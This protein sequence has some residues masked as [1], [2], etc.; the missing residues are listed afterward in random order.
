MLL[1]VWLS[2]TLPEFFRRQCEAARGHLLFSNPN[3]PPMLCVFSPTDE[4]HTLLTSLGAAAN[5]PTVLMQVIGTMLSF[6]V[7]IAIFLISG[8]AF[9]SVTADSLFHYHTDVAYQEFGSFI[10]FMGL[11]LSVCLVISFIAALAVPK[12]LRSHALG[13]GREP[14]F[15]NII[16]N[17]SVKIYPPK[18]ERCSLLQV[19]KT[20]SENMRMHSFLLTDGGTIDKIGGWILHNKR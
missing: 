17:V 7:P 11:G 2:E 5:V 10:F 4:A 15:Q 16:A 1:G 12:M 18:I 8:S 19:D 3:P 13:F 6:Y 14:L 9:L 20:A